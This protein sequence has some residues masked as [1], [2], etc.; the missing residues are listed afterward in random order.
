[1]IFNVSIGTIVNRRIYL[2]TGNIYLGATVYGVVITFVS[3]STYMF[4]DFVF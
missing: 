2:E 3:Y 1:M 4:P